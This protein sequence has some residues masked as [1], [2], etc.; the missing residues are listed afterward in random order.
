MRQCIN[1]FNKTRPVLVWSVFKLHICNSNRPQRP[2][3]HRRRHRRPSQRYS[4]RLLIAVAAQI[5]TKNSHMVNYI[6][7]IRL[8][9]INNSSSII[10]SISI[11]IITIIIS[12]WHD[13]TIWLIM[14]PLCIIITMKNGENAPKIYQLLIFLQEL[15]HWMQVSSCSCINV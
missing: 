13:T 7:P 9:I 5:A 12:F 11:N 10:T 8:F 15:Y 3:H 2:Y 14:P 6:C 1:M 4:T